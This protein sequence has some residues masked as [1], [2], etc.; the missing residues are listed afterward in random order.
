MDGYE[1]KMNVC[2]AGGSEGRFLRGFRR[3][4]RSGK[5]AGVLDL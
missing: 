5:V 4:T 2:I 3:T 1:E